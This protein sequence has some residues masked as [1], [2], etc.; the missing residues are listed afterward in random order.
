MRSTVLR[1]G[2][3]AA[4]A[5]LLLTLPGASAQPRP[6]PRPEA[7]AETKLLMEG[8]AMPN[9]RGLDRN[10]RQKPTEAEAWSFMRGQALLVAETGNLLLLRPPKSAGQ[11]AWNSNAVQLRDSAGRLARAAADRD[12]ERSRAGL[13][14]LANVCNRCH[15][16]F[17][18]ATRIPP[19]E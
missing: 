5:G 1:I 2:L 17:R 14:E 10:L 8:M 3:P 4:L 18:V 7:V 11:E 16:T 13:A 12:Y 19:K 15:Q 6:Q 9:F